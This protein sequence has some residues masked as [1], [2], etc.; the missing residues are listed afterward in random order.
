MDKTCDR[1]SWNLIKVV[2]NSMGFS[3]HWINLIMECVSTTCFQVLINGALLGAITP[4]RGLR[5]GDPLSPY[6][7]I[8]CQNV[9][10]HLFF[11]AQAQKNLHGIKINRRNPLLNHFFFANDCF[12]FFMTNIHSCRHFKNVLKEFYLLS[13]LKINYTKSKFFISPNYNTK[14]KWW[15]S[16]ILRVKNTETPSKYLGIELG[17]MNHKRSFFQ[18]LLNKI[19]KR[20]A[21][22]KG[23][24]LSQDERLTLI[25]STLASIP[26]YSLSCFKAPDYIYRKIN[27]I[28][29]SFW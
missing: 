7:F 20:L 4:T 29:R 28:V 27:Q 14:K 19:Q 9:L 17:H 1:L 11:N 3:Q 6:L 16:G 25:K 21:G 8:L 12:I 10:S 2:I 13:R 15:F 26:N 18:P 24:H 5:Q 22:W 23:H